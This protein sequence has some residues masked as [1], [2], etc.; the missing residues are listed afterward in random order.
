MVTVHVD[1]SKVVLDH[2]ARHKTLHPEV[3]DKTPGE[4]EELMDA[5]S[6]P[7]LIRLLK[8]EKDRVSC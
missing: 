1:F 5:F 8:K 3:G 6:D 4:I 2:F 7:E